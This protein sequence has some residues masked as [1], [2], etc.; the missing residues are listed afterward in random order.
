MKRCERM[1]HTTNADGQMFGYS[2]P[3]TGMGPSIT[4]VE[5]CATVENASELTGRVH[6][7]SELHGHRG[8]RRP[9]HA[10]VFQGRG[11]HAEIRSGYPLWTTAS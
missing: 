9:V 1:F 8:L 7:G 2:Y 4:A 3:R 11:W 6:A 10:R 5:P